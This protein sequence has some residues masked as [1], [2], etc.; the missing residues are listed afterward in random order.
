MLALILFKES[1]V[2]AWHALVANKL[3]TFLSL[4]GITIGIFAIITVF[5]VV[6]AL[7]QNVRKSVS[8]LGDNV[9]FVQKWPWEFG[10]EYPWWKYMNRPVASLNELAEIQRK[11][12]LAEAAAFVVEGQKNVSYRSNTIENIQISCVSADYDLVKSI[13][14]MEGRYFAQQELTGGRPKAIIGASVWLSLFGNISPIGK[15]IKVGSLKL[16]VIGVFAPE[17]SSTIG[18]SMDNVIVVPINYARNFLDIRN[19]RMNPTIHV[20]AREGISNDD[21]KEELTGI[22]RSVRKQKPLEEDNFALNETS[23]L[24]KGFNSIFDIIG[25]AGWVIGGFSIIVGGFGIA[26]IMFVSVRERTNQIGIQKSLGARNS[27]I[28]AQFLVEAVMLSLAGGIIGL[29]FVWLTLLGAN[30][31]FDLGIA[32]N[33]S[34]II[35]ALTVS[36]LIGIISGFIPSYTASQLD[37]VEAMRS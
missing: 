12:N 28:L 32:I 21:L 15:V 26:N 37:P 19:E 14:L 1:L 36:I 24:T 31:L 17:G 29:F 35:L 9:I 27:F 16:E 4:L 7:E 23:M 20:K 11:S 30:S 5:T 8:S 13:E 6:D 2:F 25:L 18:N 3:R 10:S 34:N 22:M 33:L